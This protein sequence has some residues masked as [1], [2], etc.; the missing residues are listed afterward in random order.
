MM[1]KA[2]YILLPLLA[3]LLAASVVL[4]CLLPRPNQPEASSPSDSGPA[5]QETSS[6]TTQPTSP[7]TQ[8]TEPPVTKVSTAT[9]GSTG[10]ILLHKLVIQSGYDSAT[11]GYNYDNIFKFYQQYASQVDLAVANLEVTLCGN[12]NGYPYN[13][14]PNFNAPDAIVDSLKNAGFDLLLT[15]NNHS[16]DTGHTGFLRTQQIIADRG[17]DYIGTRAEETDANYI[18]K[19]INGIS[20]GMVCYTYNT[21]V[22]ASGAVSLNGIPLSQADSKL[23]NSFNYRKL[24]S[25]YK[26][27]S[28]Q[29]QEMRDL[30]AEAIMLYIHWGDEYNTT[31]N[32]TQK[33]MA[34]ALCN[35]GVDV[36]VG[37]HAH[38]IQPVELLTSEQDASKKTVC[39]YSMGNAVS[40]IFKVSHFPV[41]TEDGLLFKVTFAKYSDG[42][43]LLER[44]DV[45]PTWVY[46]YYSENG[47]RMYTI[48]P[49]DE[50]KEKWQ[51]TMS[52]TDSI[53][54]KCQDSHQRTMGL[55]G[56]GLADVNNWCRETQ[57]AVEKALGI[58]N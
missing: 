29:M 8:P 24:D 4:V 2:L 55:V 25:F 18:V 56:Q 47:T 13:G 51:E 30:G 31:P 11:G 10:D 43:V 42:T 53:L 3:V 35:L 15:A 21:G 58:I 33:K 6:P 20:V 12:D 28:A 52:L 41:E 36:I 5:T 37:N 27:L 14:Y 23:V 17:L 38:V 1:R 49:L 22:S 34:Q 40:N 16:Y 39:L 57:T 19:E 48:L 46:R 7:P 45:L 9:I 32:A 50:N 44:A 26:K 54:K